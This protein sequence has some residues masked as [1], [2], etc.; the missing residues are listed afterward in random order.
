MVVVVVVVV[1]WCS[2]GGVCG[3]AWGGS[4]SS[5][6]FYFIGAGAQACSGMS[7]DL[8]ISPGVQGTLTHD[9]LVPQVLAHET[10]SDMRMSGLVLDI[11]LRPT[12]LQ[13]HMSRVEGGKESEAVVEL[14]DARFI[15]TTLVHGGG[16][17][18]YIRGTIKTSYKNPKP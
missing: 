5:C 3:G 10:R 12:T 18:G 17:H 8:C 1:D 15:Q 14:G 6:S 2:I 7:F 11:M 4:S 13:L 9:V 16:W